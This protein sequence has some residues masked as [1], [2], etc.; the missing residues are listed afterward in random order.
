MPSP[1]QA[2][3]AG[4]HHCE[5]LAYGAGWIDH[6]CRQ[7][8]ADTGRREPR[9][10]LWVQCC[11]ALA[12]DWTRTRIALLSLSLVWPD[13]G[14]THAAVVTAR[15]QGRH[16]PVEPAGLRRRR[17]DHPHPPRRPVAA[18]IVAGLLPASAHYVKASGT[19]SAETL[20]GAANHQPRRAVL[21]YATDDQTAATTIERLIRAAGFDPMNIGGTAS[22]GRIEAPGGDLHQFALNDG[23]V[24]DLD[25]ARAA[26]AGAAQPA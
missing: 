21:F 11:Q 18:S 20:A 22:A 19:L 10:E 5:L 3:T 9:H 1:T 16:R 24:I 8:V 25:Q 13:A 23:Q 6:E 12:I 26:M 2:A 4:T 15:G 14:G 7:A 17:P